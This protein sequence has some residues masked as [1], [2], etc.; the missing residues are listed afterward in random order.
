MTEPS[1]ILRSTAAWLAAAAALAVPA[2]HADYLWLQ[3]DAG[4]AR[5]YAGELRKPLEQLPALEDARQ[6]LPDGK[7]LP[8][9]ADANHFTADAGQGDVRIAATRPGANG[10]L[11]YYQARFGRNDTKQSC[12]TF[13]PPRELEKSS[14]P[15]RGSKN[16]LNS[17]RLRRRESRQNGIDAAMDNCGKN[18]R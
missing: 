6:V 13:T 10:V 12:E 8:L 17:G 15:T 4:Q 16:C 7:S 9:K 2:A 11:T 18:D 3:Q 5:A 14:K 1:R